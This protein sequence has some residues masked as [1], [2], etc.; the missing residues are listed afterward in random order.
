MKR[1]IMMATAAVIVLPLSAQAAKD[2]RDRAWYDGQTEI[3]YRVQDGQIY[4]GAPFLPADGQ[5]MT[6]NLVGG[7]KL[8]LDGKAAYI[9]NEKGQK[10]FANNAPQMT[11]AGITYQTM[12]GEVLY[13]TPNAEMYRIVA[14]A[15]DT[16]HDGYAD[17]VDFYIE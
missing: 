5:T 4:N 1:F 9:I 16:D 11:T 8:F 13:A 7:G 2:T 14:D 12:D 10:F 15:R 17:D 3:D 6:L